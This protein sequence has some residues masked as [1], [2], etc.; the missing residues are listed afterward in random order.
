MY[1][2]AIKR[3]IQEVTDEFTGDKEVGGT[4]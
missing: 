1:I 3:T 4:D 2:N